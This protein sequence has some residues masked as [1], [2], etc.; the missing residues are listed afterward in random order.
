MHHRVVQPQFI[1][2]HLDS[3]EGIAGIDC[4][5]GIMRCIIGCSIMGCVGVWKC[6]GASVGGKEAFVER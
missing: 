5:G 4:T 1:S 3:V 6:A 2:R